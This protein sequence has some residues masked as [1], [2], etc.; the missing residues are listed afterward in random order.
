MAKRPFYQSAFK[1]CVIGAVLLCLLAPVQAEDKSDFKI[2]LTKFTQETQ[3]FSQDAN[4]M[5]FV[6]W[7]PVDFWQE[8]FKNDPTVSR[9]DADELIDAFDD[10]VMVA[11]VD[12]TMNDYGT[13]SYKSY[14]TVES[15]LYI[16]DK[17]QKKYSPLSSSKVNAKTNEMLGAFKPIMANMLG[18]MG[19]NMHIFLFPKKDANGA[20]IDDPKGEGSFS[21]VLGTTTYKWKL[22]LISLYPVMPCEK[23]KEDCSGAWTYC[24]WCGAILPEY[25]N[26]ND[27]KEN[28][29]KPIGS[30]SG[31]FITKSG[32]II[33]AAHVVKDAT[34]YEIH[35]QSDI[36]SAKRIYI[37]DI[38]DIAVLKAIDAQIPQPLLLSDS[39]EIKTGDTVFTLGFPQVELQ[40]TEPKY[41]EGSISSISGIA[42]DRKYFQISVPVQ[43]GNSGGPL[44]DSGGGVVGLITSRLDDINTLTISGLLPQNVN[45]A[46]KSSFIFPLLGPL[47][48]IELEKS[49]KLEKSEAIERAKNAVVLIVCYDRE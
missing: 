32:H 23:C 19:Q 30:G 35:S 4:K 42:N 49:S 39:S 6:W 5:E 44:L 34:S 33:T 28:T 14:S 16:L 47:S 12:G 10:Y 20:V 3:K 15:K 1:F 18:N 13:V 27:L 22:P 25:S 31:F 11:V 9:T 40:G 26:T 36:Y 17:S 2:D 48:E 45:Y 24:P 37:D 7:I 46:L 38:L 41:T 21:V 29:D 43:P 8:S